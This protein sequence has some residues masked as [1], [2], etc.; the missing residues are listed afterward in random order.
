MLALTEDAGLFCKHGPGKV[1]I[2]A[3]QNVVTV[4]GRR[5]LVEPDPVGRSIAGCPSVVPFKP[6]LTTLAVQKGYSEFIRVENRRLCLDT[7]TGFTDGTPPGVV[8]YMVRDAGQ[9]FVTEMK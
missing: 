4:E 5:V 6:C 2:R 9:K 1:S 3:T 7:V 8:M